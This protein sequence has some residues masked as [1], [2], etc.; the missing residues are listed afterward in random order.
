MSRTHARFADLS[1]HEEFEQSSHII[2]L[3]TLLIYG[4]MLVLG[5][6]RDLLR[7]LKITKSYIK[8]ENSNMK[9]CVC[10]CA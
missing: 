5:K 4:A 2:S 6:I 8:T 7:D 3:I 1:E 9:V 10:V